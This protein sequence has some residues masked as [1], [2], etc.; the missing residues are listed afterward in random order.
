MEKVSRITSSIP[1]PDLE[2][3]PSTAPTDTQCVLITQ[4]IRDGPG[5]AASPKPEAENASQEMWKFSEA[6]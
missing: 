3:A 6:C 2:P 1:R 5:N 4:T